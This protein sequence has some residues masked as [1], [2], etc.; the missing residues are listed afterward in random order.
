M[1]HMNFL[2]N[3]IQLWLQIDHMLLSMFTDCFSYAIFQEEL[4]KNMFNMAA[5]NP[6]LA[7]LLLVTTA[8]QVCEFS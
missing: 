5:L 4:T 8:Y 6:H 2:F 1:Q 3:V 7:C